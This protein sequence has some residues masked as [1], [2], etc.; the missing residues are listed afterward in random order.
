MSKVAAEKSPVVKPTKIHSTPKSV[1]KQP[2][3]LDVKSVEKGAKLEKKAVALPTKAAEPTP[4]KAKKKLPTPPPTNTNPEI[5][6]KIRS[7]QAEKEQRKDLA[8]PTPKPSLVPTTPI[9]MIEKGKDRLVL[10]VRDAFWL[11]AHGHLPTQC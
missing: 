5:V 1:G 10:M 6:A 2:P 9:P 4:P 3:K 8:Q 7:A 11:H